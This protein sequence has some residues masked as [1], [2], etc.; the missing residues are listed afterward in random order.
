MYLPQSIEI[1][2]QQIASIFFI[3]L[4]SVFVSSIIY[5][6]ETRRDG[7]DEEKA[8]DLFIVCVLSGVLLSRLTNGALRSLP[9]EGLVIHI[10]RFWTPGFDPIGLVIGLLFPVYFFTQSWR[11]SIYRITDI[12]VISLSAGTVPLLL[13]IY[14]IS[15][16]SIFLIEAV[17]YLI[18]VI[19]LRKVRVRYRSGL[20]FSLFLF[21]NAL[22]GFSLV[23]NSFYI[24]FYICLVI[25]SV[26]NL[27]WREKRN[28]MKANLPKSFV[29]RM[30][31]LLTKKEKDLSV[32]QQLLIEEDPYMAEGRDSDNAD[33]LDDVYEDVTKETNDRRL[34][35][36]RRGLNAVKR[37]LAKIKLGSY[38]MCEVCGNSISKERLEAIPEVRTCR[39]CANSGN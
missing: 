18:I 33:V 19:A 25:L 27:Y 22:F 8:I 34:S 35:S 24:V 17:V 2:G 23:R 16:K 39:D 6:Y 12:L 4:A 29:G 7:F 32:E 5:W 11:W 38:G 31:S 1:F 10:A 28:P 21:I 20:V 3:L 36:T 14:L 9:L 13:G 26:V 15:Q 30:K 37:A